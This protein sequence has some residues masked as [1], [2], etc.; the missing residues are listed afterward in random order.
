MKSPTTPLRDARRKAGLTQVDLAVRVGL[1]RAW[2][3]LVETHPSL[4]S[5]E[6]LAR[7]AAALGLPPELVLARRHRG[8]VI[9]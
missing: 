6:T 3:Q 5:P 1:S 7:L 9:F 2:V 4:A 8:P